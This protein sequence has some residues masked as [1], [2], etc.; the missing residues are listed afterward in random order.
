MRKELKKKKETKI[1]LKNCINFLFLFEKFFS[2]FTHF[3][4]IV[5][6][7]SLLFF[8][9]INEIENV[10]RFK[11]F[12]FLFLPSLYTQIQEKRERERE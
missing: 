1:M 11:D 10:L 4:M 3:S 12:Y 9:R 7:G 2:E 8:P 6:L 5:I